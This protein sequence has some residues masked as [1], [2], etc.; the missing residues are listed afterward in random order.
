MPW[1]IPLF[2]TQTDESDTE[3]VN[4]VIERGTA[5]AGG[6]EIAEFEHKLAEYFDARYALVFNSG[7]SALHSLLLAI[8]IEGAEVIVPSFSF[9]STVNSVVIAGGRPVFA[10]IERSTMGLDPDS[11]ERD[12][13]PNTRA[14][15]VVHYAGA[16]AMFTEEI[17]ELCDKRNIFVL[18]D[19]A[20]SM[21]AE[22]NH[23]K[24][25]KFGIAAMFSFCQ[26]KIISTGEGG[27]IVTDDRV[28]YEKMK[29]IRS[30][31]RKEAGKNYF[32]D[33]GDNDY[34]ELGY[35]FRMPSMNAALGI[36]QLNRINSLIEGRRTVARRYR[37]AFS[38]HPQIRC[39]MDH[40]GLRHVY[41][42]FTLRF[43]NTELR[44]IVQME[45]AR[46]GIMSKVY[47]NPI[48]LK[49]YYM[50]KY[51]CFESQLPVTEEM[52]STVLTIP[53]YVGM[54]EEETNM[55]IDTVLN[56]TNGRS[57]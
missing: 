30:H 18:E 10:D 5:W 4:A 53:L 35:N 11:V 16:P 39:P 49:S 55:V 1:K 22:L 29:L 12:I 19:A 54:T 52:S 38:T 25:G 36:S 41:Q 15:I 2:K 31:G 57:P 32:D 24:V 23:R 6:P 34:I 46:N 51:G 17:K 44:D 8:G 45:L 42:M 21:G 43:V 9:V 47:F 33:T 48:H 14:V 26:G 3:A 27:C 37:H 50:D 56:V 7:T 28:L 20:E 40:V 13:T